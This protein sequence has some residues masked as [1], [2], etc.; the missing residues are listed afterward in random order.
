MHFCGCIIQHVLG[1]RGKPRDKQLLSC[2]SNCQEPQSG[3]TFPVRMMICLQQLMVI[4]QK[5]HWQVFVT[6]CRLTFSSGNVQ[7][8]AMLDSSASVNDN[9]G[10]RLVRPA[11]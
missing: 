9:A 4:A 10:I 6:C 2:W 1:Q 8:Y 3:W 11:C 7:F 5:L